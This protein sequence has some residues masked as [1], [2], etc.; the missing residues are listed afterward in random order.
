[1]SIKDLQKTIRQREGLILSTDTLNL[2]HLLPASYDLMVNYNMRTTLKNDIE[3][4]FANTDKDEEEKE[5]P[6]YTNQYYS[7]I[8]IPEEKAEEANYILEEVFNYFENISPNGY[9]FGNT[10]G[11]GAC[12]GFFKCEEEDC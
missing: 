3:S 11:D 10:E 5:L 9:Y 4:V 7:R 12:F 6:T 1:M 8:E 2:I